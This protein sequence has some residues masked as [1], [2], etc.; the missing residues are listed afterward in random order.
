MIF[1]RD[2]MRHAQAFNN[3][4]NMLIEKILLQ[5]AP[6]RVLMH[7]ESFVTGY[8]FAALAGR[9]VDPINTPGALPNLE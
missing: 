4:V 6:K 8:R 2:K 7:G 9:C 1:E 3:A 5:V